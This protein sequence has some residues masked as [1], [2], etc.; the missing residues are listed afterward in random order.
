MEITWITKTHKSHAGEATPPYHIFVQF[1]T[2]TVR[3]A[4]LSVRRATKVN[5][6][7]TCFFPKHL[8]S[9]VSLK[10]EKRFLS[11]SENPSP[12]FMT[13]FKIMVI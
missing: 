1:N 8:V 9:S 13:N 4:L 3:T 6:E 11:K 7:K 2:F 10:Q 12:L 5:S